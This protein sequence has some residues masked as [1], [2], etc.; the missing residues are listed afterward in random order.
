MGSVARSAAV[1]VCFLCL[2]ATAAFGLS[3]EDLKVQRKEVFEF[4]QKP[5]ISRQGDRVSIAFAVKDF[6]DATVAIE[7]RTG[8]I[9]SHLASGVLGK[10]APAP[11]QKD[12]LKQALVWDGKNDKG[13]YVDDRERA[14]IRVSLGLKPQFER[15]LFWSP[16]KKEPGTP[17]LPVAAAPEGVYVLDGGTEGYQIRLFDHAGNYVR[18]VHP[19]PAG[20]VAGLQGVKWGAFPPDDFRV[21]LR[22]AVG[23]FL[24]TDIDATTGLPPTRFSATGIRAMAVQG[25]QIFVACQQ[26]NRLATDGTTGGARL[27][28][29]NVVFPAY[30]PGAHGTGGYV[31]PIVPEGMAASPDGKWL[32]FAGYLWRTAY[33]EGCLNGVARL[34]TDSDTDARAFLGTMDKTPGKDNAHFNA[35]SSVAC[36]SQ[37][38]LYVGDYINDRVQVYSP[39]GKHLKTIPVTRPAVVRVDRKNNDLWVFTWSLQRSYAPDLQYRGPA[40]VTHLGPFDNPA[41]IA[42]YP[43]SVTDDWGGHTAEIDPWTDP[44]T[45]WMTDPAASLMRLYV[46]QG[47]KLEIKRDFTLE[48]GKELVRLRPPGHS[49]WRL[50]VNPKNGKCYIAEDHFPA[51]IIVKGS[52]TLIELDPETG[53]QKIID[54]A[55]DA[56]DVAF[57]LDGQ[58][59]LRAFGYI[60]R[61]SGETWKEV[62]FDYG[63]N[64]RVS[65]QGLRETEAVSAAPFPDAGNASSQMGG[66]WVS[67]NGH[68]VVTS[69]NPKGYDPK[70][71][72]KRVTKT[73]TGFGGTKDIKGLQLMPGRADICVIRILDRYGRLLYDDA[74]PGVGFSEG[75]AMDKDDNL[76]VMAV[77]PGNLGGKPYPVPYACTLMK[78]RPK[79][80]ILTPGTP[81]AM[82]AKPDRPPDVLAWRDAGNSWVEDLPG[83]GPR[84]A[85]PGVG[86]DTQNGAAGSGKCHCVGNSRFTLD[87]FGRSF[88]PEL[89]RYDVVVLD[90]NGNAIC[91]IGRYGNVDDGV[92]LVKAGGPPNPQSLGGDEVALM[93]GRFV[94]THTDHRLFIGDRGNGRILS[95]LLNYHTTERVSLADAPEMRP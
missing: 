41:V 43:L 75:V 57:D 1:G 19:P 63:E 31:A 13:E 44:P 23:G 26:V 46:P 84:W 37:G 45:I 6:C 27:S 90:T 50:H 54:L 48:A 24:T 51:A 95:V 33:F 14:V 83:P 71:D 85:F 81:I 82:G 42:A 5:E 66:F 58:V 49:R 29:P 11:F 88:A 17:F 92:P 67:P 62:P 8:R 18:T 65:Y 16:K 12:S 35:A 64:Q 61:Y 86:M 30:L 7:D 76:Y 20:Q 91:R 56:E 3:T 47:R 68:I 22:P 80:K 70:V 74:A 40:M 21:P 69:H 77:T 2:G 52:S 32:Y 87:L 73:V 93:A 36:D 25:K 15:T 4:A 89:A 10:N 38:R 60:G 55:F 34:A 53:K 59:H 72:Q 28:G 9:L 78:F 79:T 94:A 39:E